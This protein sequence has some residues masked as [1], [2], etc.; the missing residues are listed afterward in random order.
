M[1]YGDVVVV[2]LKYLYLSS[3]TYGWFLSKILPM[4]SKNNDR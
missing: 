1:P 2:I 3:K 4:N